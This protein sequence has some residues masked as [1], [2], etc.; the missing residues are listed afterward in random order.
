M[1]PRYILIAILLLLLVNFPLLSAANHDWR[2]GGFPVLFI[3]IGAIWVVG[4]LL[5]YLTVR[6]FKSKADE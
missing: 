5:L 6:R 1:S 2:P 3:Y 4:I